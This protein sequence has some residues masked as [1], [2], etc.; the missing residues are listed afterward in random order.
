MH[1]L[2]PLSGIL[3]S[4]EN[5]TLGS[6]LVEQ[7]NQCPELSSIFLPWLFFHISLALYQDSLESLESLKEVLIKV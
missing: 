7:V 5:H 2:R 3:L 6:N 4:L 1:V